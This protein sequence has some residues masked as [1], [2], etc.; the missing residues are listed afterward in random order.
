VLHCNLGVPL[1]ISDDVAI[2][3]RAVVHNKYIGPR[4]LIATGAIVLD[5]AE[6]GADCLIAAGALV[7]PRAVIPDGSVV[8]G[9]PGTVV[10]A[11]RDTEREYIQH[12]TQGYIELAQLHATGAFLAYQPEEE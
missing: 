7:P 1:E 9:V 12:V 4:T 3:H 11:I 10:R 5:D 8:M 2:G 6:I